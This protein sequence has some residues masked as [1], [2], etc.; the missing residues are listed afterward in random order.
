MYHAYRIA[1][2]I[3]RLQKGYDYYEVIAGRPYPDDRKRRHYIDS[4]PQTMYEQLSVSTPLEKWNAETLKVKIENII[5]IR[6]KFDAQESLIK[7][8]KSLLFNSF[9]FLFSSF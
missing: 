8:K 3:Q 4:M 5:N 6:T 1:G 7:N 9:H 2:A